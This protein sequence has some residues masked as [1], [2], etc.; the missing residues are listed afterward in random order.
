MFDAKRCGYRDQP[1]V[2]QPIDLKADPVDV[3]AKEE[4]LD[5]NEVAVVASQLVDVLQAMVVRDNRI[6]YIMALIGDVSS[7]LQGAD[8]NVVVDL[9][10]QDHVLAAK[11]N[12]NRRLDQAVL[13]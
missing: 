4:V 10:A 13:S 1:V 8:A 3:D 5:D 11:I 6:L 2:L 9:S 7:Y 12:L